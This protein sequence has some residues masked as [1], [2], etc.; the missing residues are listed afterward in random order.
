MTVNRIKRGVSRR[1]LD[2][3]AFRVEGIHKIQ[4]ES[5]PSICTSLIQYQHQLPDLQFVDHFQT[6]EVNF[7][8]K[9]KKVT[10]LYLRRLPIELKS[11]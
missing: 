5:F 6:F 2:T 4:G 1:V 9:E 10:E 7:I 8:A 11:S 3:I